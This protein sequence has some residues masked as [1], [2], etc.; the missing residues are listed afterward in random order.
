MQ[1]I[2]ALFVS[3]QQL[4][5]CILGFIQEYS[6]HPLANYWKRNNFTLTIVIK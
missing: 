2:K 5:Y 4:V 1:L 6:I 3:Y